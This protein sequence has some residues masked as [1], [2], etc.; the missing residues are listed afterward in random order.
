MLIEVLIE[1]KKKHKTTEKVEMSKSQRLT[2]FFNN[3]Y[4]YIKKFAMEKWLNHPHISINEKNLQNIGL[5][6]NIN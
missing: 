1:V 6:G 5:N 4:K 3:R 2:H